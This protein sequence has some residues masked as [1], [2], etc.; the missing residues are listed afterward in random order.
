MD[1]KQAIEISQEIQIKLNG[2]KCTNPDC[3]GL[4]TKVGRMCG[5]AVKGTP[6]VALAEELSFTDLICC[7]QFQN[8]LQEKYQELKQQY[9][10]MQ[11]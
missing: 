7:E 1:Y 10:E 4:E 9:V 8:E 3:D 2:M 6:P 5:A 11:E